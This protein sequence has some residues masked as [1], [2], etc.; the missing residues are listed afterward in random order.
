MRGGGGTF[1]PPI[2][3]ELDIIH[4]VSSLSA[5][6]TATSA[7]SRCTTCQHYFEDA[8]LANLVCQVNKPIKLEVRI[9]DGIQILAQTSSFGKQFVSFKPRVDP[10]RPQEASPAPA[11]HVP[12]PGTLAHRH[13]RLR[14]HCESLRCADLA[15]I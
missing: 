3:C 15:R 8:I 4:L 9:S 12:V 2:G 7:H 6:N 10:R 14:N 11:E 13:A 1:V 5:I